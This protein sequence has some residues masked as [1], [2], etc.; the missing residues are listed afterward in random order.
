MEIVRP[1][2]HGDPYEALDLWVAIRP[3]LVR[4]GVGFSISQG[5]RLIGS[6]AATGR[7]RLVSS[8]GVPM[9]DC[10]FAGKHAWLWAPCR[11]VST[12]GRFIGCRSS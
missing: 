12:K 3:G 1:G 10:D 4:R 9:T 6:F 8:L 2:P 11:P 7:C 5:T